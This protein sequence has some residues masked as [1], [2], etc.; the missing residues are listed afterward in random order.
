MLRNRCRS[1]RHC[2]FWVCRLVPWHLRDPDQFMCVCRLYM[3]WTQA[4][5]CPLSC[6][7]LILTGAWFG[8]LSRVCLHAYLPFFCS[9][10]CP[11]GYVHLYVAGYQPIT[12][13]WTVSPSRVH[14]L[15]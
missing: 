1:H 13:I 15:T 6:I 5:L 12:E 14:P 8:A 4:F 10:F 7:C 9:L 11:P 3:A 2:H